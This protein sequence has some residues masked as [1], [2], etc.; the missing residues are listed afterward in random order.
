MMLDI[1]NSFVQTDIFC[2]GKERIIMKLRG[3]MVD[4]LW[5]IDSELYS[6][7]VVLKNG[8]KYSMSKY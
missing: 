6:P 1:Q 7:Y 3:S 2:E 4:M 8:E 5:D